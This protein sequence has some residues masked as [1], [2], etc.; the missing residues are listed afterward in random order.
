MMA[1]LKKE[2]FSL[3]GLF[4]F[5]LFMRQAALHADLGNVALTLFAC[6]CAFLSVGAVVAV[7]LSEQI[8]KLIDEVRK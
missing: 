1:F 3:A 8:D 4:A 5:V 7:A 2:W 6:F